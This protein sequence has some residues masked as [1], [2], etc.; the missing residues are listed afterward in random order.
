MRQRVMEDDLLRL[1]STTIL[2]ESVVRLRSHMQQPLDM[3]A[4]Q[5][6][7]LLGSTAFRVVLELAGQ[8]VTTTALVLIILRFRGWWICGRS[9]LAVRPR[10]DDPG[11]VDG[12]DGRKQNFQYVLLA[13]LRATFARVRL[14]PIQTNHDPPDVA[15]HFHPPSSIAPGPGNLVLPI[16]G[17]ARRSRN[18][19]HALRG[20]ITSR[21][22]P[23][24]TPQ[25]LHRT[26]RFYYASDHTYLA[27][28]RPDLGGNAIT[29]RHVC[30]FWTEDRL[31]YQAVGDDSGGSG[32]MGGFCMG[33][34]CLAGI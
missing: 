30:W 31:A 32:R 33:G 9:G 27:Q 26:A 28:L 3:A 25:W 11:A 21:L 24:P 7:R 16:I 2:A 6:G 34:T 19:L 1:A 12:V 29:R 10:S 8:Y 14:K 17:S 23:R 15:L 18:D 5:F 13:A 4:L 22:H 20:T